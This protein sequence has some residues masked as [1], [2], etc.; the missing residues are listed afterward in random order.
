[1]SR[2]SLW[3][4]EW[5]RWGLDAGRSDR[6]VEKGCTGCRG[7]PQVLLDYQVEAGLRQE[8]EPLSLLG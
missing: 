2:G 5:V 6:W 7:S 8:L 3:L 1:M 4:E